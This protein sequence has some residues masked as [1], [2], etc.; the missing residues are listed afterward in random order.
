[1]D[2]DVCTLEAVGG[3]IGSLGGEPVGK[4]PNL[5]AEF[6][7]AKVVG[8]QLNQFI[9]EDAGTAWLKKD[10]RKA[11]VDLRG[12][13][14][15]DFDEVTARGGEE[16]EVI[17]GA[18]AAD[19]AL[20]DLDAEASLGEHLFS[21]DEGMG[22]VVVVPGVWPEEDYWGCEGGSAWHVAGGG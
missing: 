19:V 21:G 12:H 5:A 14:I 6:F 7:G 1:V 13:A 20:G 18:A 10:E 8:E 16:S 17:E 3:P 15:E 9:F 2:E 4:E 11:R 22:V